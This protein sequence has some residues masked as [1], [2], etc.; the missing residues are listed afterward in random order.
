MLVASWLCFTVLALVWTGGA[1]VL[2]H[3]LNWGA[4][5][6][7]SG[8]A[9]TT[10]QDIANASIPQWLT[11]LF[12][13]RWIEAMR[14]LAVQ[15][16]DLARSAVPYADPAAGWLITAAWLVWSVG[17][18]L[19]LLLAVLSHLVIQRWRGRNADA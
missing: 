5:A 6:F 7:R 11:V 2:A 3:L 13:E 12:D 8:V 1:L 9:T 18:L 16:L 19:L 10:T 15:V 4:A 14:S 17:M